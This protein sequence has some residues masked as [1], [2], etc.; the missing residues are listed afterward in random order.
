MYIHNV[1]I[2]EKDQYTRI[3]DTDFFYIADKEKMSIYKIKTHFNEL[4]I[5]HNPTQIGVFKGDYI[6]KLC[7]FRIDNKNRFKF[8]GEAKAPKDP[9]LKLLWEHGCT[10][11]KRKKNYD[12]ML[13]LMKEQDT[14]KVVFA[15]NLKGEWW[16]SED[17]LTMEKVKLLLKG[18]I[19]HVNDLVNKKLKESAL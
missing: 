10:G 2:E 11:A 17:Y 18:M 5:D 9:V 16:I 8:M 3:K 15:H 6:G 1:M 12:G 4:P 13:I 7:S 19:F 14:Q